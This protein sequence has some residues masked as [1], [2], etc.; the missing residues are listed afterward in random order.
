VAGQIPELDQHGYFERTRTHAYSLFTRLYDEA[1]PDD[2]EAFNY[3]IDAEDAPHHPLRVHWNRV[4]QD[5]DPQRKPDAVT[6]EQLKAAFGDFLERATELL[7][8]PDE[9]EEE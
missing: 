8:P 4:F 3:A 1:E 6:P 5:Y 9:H 7:L 2:L